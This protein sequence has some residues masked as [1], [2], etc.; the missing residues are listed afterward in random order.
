MGICGGCSKILIPFHLFLPLTALPLGAAWPEKTLFDLLFPSVFH[1]T[2]NLFWG[3]LPF[4]QLFLSS[5][6]I[7]YRLKKMQSPASFLGP[8]VLCLRSGNH[9]PKE[10][11]AKQLEL[12]DLGKEKGKEQALPWE[13]GPSLG[14]FRACCS[15]LFIPTWGPSP[16]CARASLLFLR[17]VGLRTPLPQ[18]PLGVLVLHVLSLGTSLESQS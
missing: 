14:G 7:I 5:S 10:L 11:S 9:P 4:L 13:R 3:F 8:S 16:L 2:H 1:F 17:G 15:L 18:P 12:W 6:C